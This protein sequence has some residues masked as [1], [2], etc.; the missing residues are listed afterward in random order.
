M[1][2]SRKK[3][4]VVK[5]LFAK[6]SHLFACPICNAN[7]YMTEPA[8][9]QCYNR[10]NF[11]LARQGYVNLL[12]G[13]VKAGKYDRQLFAARLA[14]NQSGF[15]SPLLA[16]LYA[17]VVAHSSQQGAHPLRLL[18]AGC[19]EGS[20]LA[21]LAAALDSNSLEVVAV[22]LDLA[23]DGIRLAAASYPGV[24]W[25]VADLARCPLRANQWDVIL[26]IFSPANYAEFRRLLKPHGIVVKV[27]PGPHYLQELRSALFGD[28]AKATYKND[29]SRQQFAQQF[30]LL[31][32]ERVNYQWEML[33]SSLELLLQ[34]TPLAWSAG[35][36]ALEAVRQR[37]LPQITVDARILVG[38]AEN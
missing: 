33:P 9:F 24:L 20:H 38:T 17:S 19:G 2:K 12:T 35:E 26:N 6:H 30:T 4:D 1:D 28:T 27:I 3:I 37:G 36:A 10:H 11:D 34:M 32:E 23:K 22:G 8:I 25:C 29:G 31:G 16:A 7:M 15:F 21:H 13:R 18:D 14:L 5:D